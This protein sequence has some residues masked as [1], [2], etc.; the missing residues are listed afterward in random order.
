[1]AFHAGSRGSQ[2]SYMSSFLFPLWAN[3]GLVVS[4]V[5]MPINRATT[6]APITIIRTPLILC[7]FTFLQVFGKFRKQHLSRETPRRDFHWDRFVYLY[8]FR[9]LFRSRDFRDRAQRLESHRSQPA[10]LSRWV[11]QGGR[12]RWAR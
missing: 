6:N 1:M 11:F 2:L 10:T 3:A 5:Q 8:R 12:I 9:N 4:V 7:I